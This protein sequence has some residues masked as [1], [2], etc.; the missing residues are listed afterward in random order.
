MELTPT[1]QRQFE[2]LQMAFRDPP[3]T[4]EELAQLDL[5]SDESLMIGMVLMGREQHPDDHALPDVHKS[6]DELSSATLVATGDQLTFSYGQES[7]VASYSVL[8]QAES[9]LILE[10]VSNTDGQ[11]VVEKVQVSFEGGDLLTLQ[12]EGDLEASQQSFTR[13]RDPAQTP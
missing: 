3:P 7:D 1:Q 4:R 12:V 2:L 13:R 9:S 11:R 5:S 10:T 6:L 8:E